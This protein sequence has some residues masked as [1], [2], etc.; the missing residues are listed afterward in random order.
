MVTSA[1]RINSGINKTLHI[2]DGVSSECSDSIFSGL[3]TMSRYSENVSNALSQ[4]DDVIILKSKESKI[5]T[6]FKK[7]KEKFEKF[8]LD[9]FGFVSK[10]ENA[11]VL[12]QENHNRKRVELE[13]DVVS[14]GEDTLTH[15]V[16]HLVD[17]ELSTGKKFKKA[18]LS[19]LK[20]IYSLLQNGNAKVCGENLNDMLEYLKHYTEGVDFSDGIDGDDITREGL[21]ENFAE[22]FSTIVDSHPT[23]INKIF[24]AL[25]PNTMQATRGLIA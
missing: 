13:G 21:R 3:Q 11:I 7:T 15:E 16:G 22:C 8:A 4:I 9:A 6:Q 2:S 14:Q 25:F 12:V 24:S 20:Q 5:P 10:K 17:K 23:K 18:Y 1:Q 19:D